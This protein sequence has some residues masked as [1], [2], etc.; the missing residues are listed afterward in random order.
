MGTAGGTTVTNTTGSISAQVRANPTAGF[1][2]VT[3]TG[4][5]ANATIGHG[6][7]VAPRMIIVKRRDAADIWTTYHESIGNTQ[8]LRLQDTN[9]AG[10]Y[11]IWQNTSPTS[12][13]FYISTDTTVNTSTGTYV[14]YCWAEVAGY[15]KFGS[16]TG[17]GSTDGPFVYCGFRPRY[18]MWKQT[19]ATG[20]YWEIIDSTR[21]TYNVNAPVLYANVSSAEES[22]SRAD[23][24]SNGFKLRQT[25]AGSNASGSTYIYMAFAESP[26]KY[27]RAR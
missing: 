6:L 20:E 12:S 17:N 25:N 2:I 27:A 13:V 10:T 4:T 15:S 23:F 11:N 5:S 18:V 3:Y 1:S 22:A 8:Y 26:L 24:L 7:G 9:Q 16:Y 19:N 21:G 14:A